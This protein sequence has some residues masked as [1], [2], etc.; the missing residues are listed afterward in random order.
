M[1]RVT[2]TAPARDDLDHIWSYIAN[3]N[4]S[5]ADRWIDEVHR[6]CAV[7]ARQPM[8]ATPADRFQIGLRFFTHGN[9]VVFFRPEGDGVLVVRVLHGARHLEDLFGP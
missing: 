5:A 8:A 2:L 9:Y 7:Y 3:D 6:R 1:A 4:P